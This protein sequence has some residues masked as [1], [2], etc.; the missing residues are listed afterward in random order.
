[1]IYKQSFVYI[2][3]SSNRG[4]LYIGVTSDIIKRVYEHKHCVIKGFTSKYNVN[5]LVYYEVFEDIK[6]AI[7]R[8]KKLKKWQ[9]QWKINL[10]ESINLYWEDLYNKI[11]N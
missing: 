5:K 8:E 9:R 2:L 10:I 11:I 3:A 7:A 6:L 4:T 1:M